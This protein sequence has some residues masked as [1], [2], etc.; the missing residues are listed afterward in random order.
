MCISVCVHKCVHVH[1]HICVR[2]H[3]RLYVYMCNDLFRDIEILIGINLYLNKNRISSIR[4]RAN[5]R[6]HRSFTV[7]RF[8]SH[9]QA[10]IRSAYLTARHLLGLLSFYSHILIDTIL[11]VYPKFHN[12]M[13]SICS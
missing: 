1:M 10:Y 11:S 5:L 12:S 4:R 7:V 9:A 13:D 3:V 6:I 2:A 8:V